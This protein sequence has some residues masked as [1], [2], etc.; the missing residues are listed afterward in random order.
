MN[1]TRNNNSEPRQIKQF[2]TEFYQAMIDTLREGAFVVE[3]KCFKL[4]NEAFCRLTGC[5]KIDLV[6]QKFD[7]FIYPQNETISFDDLSKQTS[8]T[9]LQTPIIREHIQSNT[10]EF[11]LVASHIS[12]STAPIEINSQHF[13]DSKGQLYQIANIRKKSVEQALNLAL[14]ESEK[15][16]RHLIN[17]LPDIYLHTNSKGLIDKV[18]N[19]TCQ[20]L[21]YE[22]TELIGIPLSELFMDATQ[23]T[24]AFSKIMYAKG[25]IVEQ[26]FS[27]QCKNGSKFTSILSS[28]AR[29]DKNQDFRGIECFT[30][31]TKN[32]IVPQIA[33]DR[34][35]I[36][37]PLTR[38]INQLAFEEHLAKS[39]RHARR[40]Q[41]QLWVLYVSL[42]NLSD[43]NSK[44]GGDVSDACLVHFSQRM[45]SFFRETDVVARIGEDSFGVLLD[46]YTN[47]LALG[48]L[49]SR[50]Q[51]LMDK[52]ATISQYP[53]GFTFS[54]GTAN[55]P[56][57]GVNSGDLMKHAESMMYKFKFSN[58]NQKQS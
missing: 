1:D 17:L 14:R 20:M 44:F 54:I 28:Y 21:G 19:H 32:K 52:R 23:Q 49:I 40:H 39:I 33:S 15:D 36:C 42:Q 56:I 13:I 27:F 58:N 31:T 6:G 16:L 57:D 38:L 4:V 34:T 8:I 51:Q 48:D 26:E 12:G 37:D 43:I 47:E 24:E 45:Q 3:N 18:S 30:L 41:S 35:L 22:Y 55:Y 46:D 5:S 53:Y 9:R 2:D 7:S 50:L 29:Y 10:P 11:H 25:E